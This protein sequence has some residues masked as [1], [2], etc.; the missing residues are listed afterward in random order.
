MKAKTY[1]SSDFLGP[2][3]LSSFGIKITPTLT[4][5][6]EEFNFIDILKENKLAFVPAFST[7]IR[8]D[9]DL[10]ELF[11]LDKENRT[12]VKYAELKGVQQIKNEEVESIRTMLDTVF[13]NQVLSNERWELVFGK[14]S[15]N[16]KDRWK[17]YYQT[18]SVFPKR[19]DELRFVLNVKYEEINFDFEPAN[20]KFINL[21]YARIL[22][23]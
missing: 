7:R 9:V 10:L 22:Y 20:E 1:R 18:N 13:E 17:K 8:Q 15:E 19:R 6:L 5:G 3:N 23:K 4:L 12:N 11:Y 16:A 2:Q 14:E 21:R